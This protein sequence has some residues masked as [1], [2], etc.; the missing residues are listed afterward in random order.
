MDSGSAAGDEFLKRTN[1][2]YLTVIL[3]YKDHIESSEALYI[4]DLPRLIEPDNAAVTALAG[5][6]K[7]DFEGYEYARDFAKAAAK[8]Y[9]YV[10]G[11]VSTVPLPIQFWQRP[12]E[13]LDNRAGDFFDKS[14]LLCSTLVALGC[15]SSR[16]VLLLDGGREVAVCFEIGGAITTYKFDDED[17]KE[18]ADMK[19]VRNWLMKSADN[20]A[21]AYAFNNMSCIN[22]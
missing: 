9:E 22:L 11:Y 4:P 18:F 6:I 10:R 3:R 14:V 7:S 17:A 20:D 1:S 15:A 13:T 21:Q 2:L 19:S 5:R 8:A 16:V 12:N